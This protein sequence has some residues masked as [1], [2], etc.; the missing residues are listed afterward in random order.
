MCEFHVRPSLQ[1]TGL[2]RAL[3]ARLLS[4]TDAQTA[5]LTTPDTDTRARRFYERNGW[6]PDGRTNRYEA[7]DMPTIGY[8][9]R[10]ERL[11]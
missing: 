6:E 7:F 11:E 10:L 1:G 9:K 5:V 4:L 3:M 2:G 8:T